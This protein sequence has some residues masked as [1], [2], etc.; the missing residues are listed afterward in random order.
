MTLFLF[1]AQ[2]AVIAAP[3]APTLGASSHRVER[4]MAAPAA[5]PTF[6][7]EFD[8]ARVDAARWQFDRSRNAQGWY[9]HERQYYGPDNARIASGSLVIEARAET[10]TKA[11]APDWGGQAYTS[12]KLVSRKAFGYGFYEVRARLPCGR[13]TWPAIWLLPSGGAWPAAGEI[14]IMEMVGSDPN[15]V[16]AT[17]HSEAYNHAKGTQRG[18]QV[19]VPTA[20]TAF[21]TYQLDWQAD[22][23]LIGVDGRGY[24]R[25][26]N[27][28]PGD[29]AAW[30]FTRPYRL[31]L[32]LA[33]GG[34]WGGAK[35]IDDA[36]LP[37]R[38]TVDYVRYWASARP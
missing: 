21:H 7:D 27:D 13:G 5:L 37:Q 34:D 6:A 22:A 10:L 32:N 28:R 17:L 38:M 14:D 33:V 20:C 25:V 18:A 30:P 35:G 4:A 31:I 36:A 3:P 1:V 12:A 16:H 19:T 15:V 9:N 26:A 8:G 11:R 29:A 2:A 23:I 24:M